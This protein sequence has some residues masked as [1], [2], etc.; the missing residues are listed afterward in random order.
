[1]ELKVPLSVPLV[2]AHSRSRRPVQIVPFR[3]QRKQNQNQ[4]GIAQNSPPHL[5][6]GDGILS[7]IPPETR[8]QWQSR[9][10]Q[11]HDHHALQSNHR[12]TNAFG[13]SSRPETSSG[14]WFGLI[15][16]FLLLPRCGRMETA[17]RTSNPERPNHPA[18][19][20]ATASSR[21]AGISGP[22][23]VGATQSQRGFWTHRS[24]KAQ[25][26]GLLLLRIRMPFPIR[27]LNQKPKLEPNTK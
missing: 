6:I 12:R 27:R 4:L 13:G 14:Q 18:A 26:H 1:M 11:P 24:E 10:P 19:V 21:P 2:K 17:A 23:H 25:G 15:D 20:V 9:F 7:N 8:Q 5:D 22:F 16:R 3:T